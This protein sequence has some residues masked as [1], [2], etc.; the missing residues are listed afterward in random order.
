MHGIYIPTLVYCVSY[1]LGRS[2]STKPIAK[3]KVDEIIMHMKNSDI[4]EQQ[5]PSEIFK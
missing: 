5:Q 3:Q 4:V 2:F 1:L